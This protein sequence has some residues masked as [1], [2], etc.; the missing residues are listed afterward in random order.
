MEL[1]VLENDENIDAVLWIGG[2]GQSGFNAVG[3][4]LTGE[5]NPSGKTADTYVADLLSDPANINFSDPT[6]WS[7]SG[8]SVNMYTNVS[9]DNASGYYAFVQYEEGIYVGYRYYETAYAEALN[10]NY[11]GFDYDKAVV[12]P[13]GYG[14]SY[15]SFDWEVVSTDLNVD[16]TGTMTVDVKVTNTG[17]V[18]GKD[19]VELYYSAPYTPG[20]IEK[21]AVVLGAFAKT[22]ELQP[23]ES[24][25]VTLSLN[26]EDMASYDS[27]NERAYVL[28]KGDYILSLRTDSHNVKEG[29]DTY[30]F[31]YTVNDTIVYSGDNSRQSDEITATNVFDENMTGISDDFTVM[32][33]SD[34]AGTFPTAAT[35]VDR[36]A[37]DEL[38]ADY[39]QAYDGDAV[40]TSSD[41]EAITTNA[42]NGIDLIELRGLDYDDPLWDDFLDQLTLDE[43][44][45]LSTEGGFGTAAVERL[46]ILATS[47][48]DGPAALK[49]KGLGT[50][51]T[52]DALTGFP[53]EVVIASTWNT[54]LAY[55]YGQVVGNESLAC[56][57][58]GWYAP[59][60]NT[61]RSAFA[62]RNFEYYSEDGVLAGNIATA[63][64]SGVASKGCFAYMKHFAMN[65]QESYRNCDSTG[66]WSSDGAQVM[67]MTWAD[68]QTI[69]EIYLKPFELVVKNSSTELNYISDDEGTMSTKTV[70]GV[71]AVMSSFNYIGNTWAGGNSNLLTTILR[72][73]WGFDGTVVT[74]ACFYSY[75]DY[76]QLI[77][78]GGSTVLKTF[79]VTEL[80]DTSSSANLQQNLRRAA[81]DLCYTKVNSNAY[82]NVKPGSKITY[83]M[84]PWQIMYIIID[85]IGVIGIILCVVA[86]VRGNKKNQK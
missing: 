85:V 68:E 13:F 70:S 25:T 48:N 47:D 60:V 17:D 16:T 5:I 9:T 54:N 24:E 84:A 27:N 46:G 31:T 1:D 34:F 32:S 42:D 4:I 74:D 86:I 76:N 36:T 75:M 61:H 71:S 51:A 28:D 23:G 63:Q 33:R 82:N 18:S 59:G 72:D 52:S 7:E 79:L 80:G 41:A 45:T 73:E 40:D 3:K 2:G 14:L 57:T 53:T 22:G 44:A 39:M 77:R 64:I 69:R 26:V 67:L 58:N 19:V 29:S 55:A 35:D 8:A 62:G 50:D 30:E 38:I 6:F 49:T 37:S 66:A 56:G 12:Y 83:K 65:E 81:H 15:T 10:G 43:M 21:S 20:G 78:N 11:D